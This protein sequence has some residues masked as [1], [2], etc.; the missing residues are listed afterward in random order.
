ML[1]A[2]QSVLFDQESEFKCQSRYDNYIAFSLDLALLLKV[3]AGQPGVFWL[4]WWV[5]AWWVLAGWTLAG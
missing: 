4:V 3:G 1:A 5:L 2:R